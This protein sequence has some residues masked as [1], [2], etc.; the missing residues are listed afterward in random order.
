MLFNIDDFTNKIIDI[1][2]DDPTILDKLNKTPDSSAAKLVFY[3]IK[4]IQKIHIH[5]SNKINIVKF[6]KIL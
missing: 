2:V 1:N 6:L 3:I 5:N 4:A